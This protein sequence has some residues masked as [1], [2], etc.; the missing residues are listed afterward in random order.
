[1][2]S[3]ETAAKLTTLSGQAKSTA[4]AA[5]LAAS[6]KF[7]DEPVPG[8]GL[9]P[10]RLMYDYA[11]DY[12]KSVNADLETLPTNEG[13]PYALCQQPLSAD[14]SERMQRFAEFV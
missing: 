5:A 13:E 4:A 2:R 6:E 3:Q 10:W 11:R 12:V 1:V 14:A 9:P 8:V 7:K